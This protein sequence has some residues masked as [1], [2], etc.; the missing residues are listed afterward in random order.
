M[1]AVQLNQQL[2]M[3]LAADGLVSRELYLPLGEAHGYGAASTT[4]WV[5]ARLCV[6]A[7]RVESSAPLTLD[8]PHGT[9]LMLCQSLVELQAWA[10]ENF[11][12]ARMKVT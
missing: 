2:D 9:Q 5:E 11:P 10:S 1:D 6:L 7:K 8:T 4:V 12:D 3:E